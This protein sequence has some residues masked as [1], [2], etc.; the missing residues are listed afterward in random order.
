V[1]LILT[2]TGAE[3]G[4]FVRPGDTACLACIAAFRREADPAW[5]LLASQLLSLAPPA[6]GD[7]LVME[8]AFA[9]ARLLIEAGR[10]EKPPACHSLTLREDSMHRQTRVHR[11]HA[12]CRC[13]SLGESATAAAPA[14]LG[15]TTETAFARPA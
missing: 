3:V 11:P 15:T 9:T 5:P 14:F 6:V 7:A 8:A 4:P 1:P 12:E 13:R 2:G 10:S